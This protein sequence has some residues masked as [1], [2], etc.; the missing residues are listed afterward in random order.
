MR[1]VA[2]PAPDG[3][4][5]VIVGAGSAGCV[6]A[7]RLAETPSHRILLIE[8][9]G[10]DRR[11]GIAMP[12]A[13]GLPLLS[14]ATNWK[15][16]SAPDAT[17]PEGTYMPRGRVLG[18]SSSV[19]GM[20]WMRGNPEDYDSWAGL[21]VPGWTM[22]D[23]LPYFRMSER[24]EDG[25]SAFR[26][27]SGPVGVER[28]PCDNPLFAGFLQ[29]GQQ[30][31]HPLNPDQNGASQIGMHQIQRNIRAGRRQNTSHVYL[32]RASPP[33]VDVLTGARVTRLTFRRKACTGVDG[34]TAAGPFHAAAG[35]EVILC[36]GAL[37][38]P[39]ILLLSGVGD[40]DALRPLG[41]APVLHQPGVGDGLSDH[42]CL[43]VD[44]AL[45]DEGLSQARALSLPGMAAMGAA[46]ALSRRGLGAG[47]WFEAGAMLSTDG[48]G[49]ADIQMECAALRPAFGHDAIRVRP[50]FHC[51]L[52]LQRPTSTGRVWID[53]SDPLAPPRFALGLL[54]TAHD[55]ALAVA[56]MAALRDIMG[57]PAARRLFKGETGRSEAAR[58]PEEILGWATATAE[59][60][61]HPSCTLAMGRVTDSAGLLF[62]CEALR[63][64]D[65]SILPVIPSANLNAPVIMM[66]EKIAA[67]MRRDDKRLRPDEVPISTRPHIPPTS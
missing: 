2:A 25:A 34:L 19:N 32:R 33:N 12:A 1:R 56:A 27:G 58:T 47:N 35:R 5:Y 59:S 63:I 28:A 53:T 24:F 23:A 22:A 39:Q 42:T 3:Y 38:S 30:L 55:R 49:R 36:A 15:L 46:W 16:F 62:G 41:I 66:A 60:N 8:A 40:A 11:M 29:A 44:F 61:Y 64:V 17:R 10:S 50:G 48:T 37:M 6:M 54:R 14:D 43:V 26:G 31:G 21:G 51:S 9:G 67:T 18:G 45:Q 7:A 13:M 4:D 65:A 57:Q 20:N 52:S